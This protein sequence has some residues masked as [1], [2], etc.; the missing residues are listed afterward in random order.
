[1]ILGKILK[2][3]ETDQ[4]EILSDEQL[5]ERKIKLTK[6]LRRRNTI[7]RITL[8]FVI[9]L[10]ICGGYKSLFSPKQSNSY[11]E[12]MDQSFLNDYLDSYY[13]YPQ[14][15]QS[16]DY[17]SKF[18]LSEEFYRLEYD[19]SVE[20]AS[21]SDSIIYNVKAED[22]I[23]NIYS[24]YVQSNYSV[25]V[26]DS[27]TKTKQI[28]NK[29]TVAKSDNKYKVV[30]PVENV[31]DSVTAIQDEKVLDKY[32]Y[33]AESGSSNVSDKKKAEI[34]NTLSLFLKTYNDDIKQA[35]L[36]VSNPGKLHP[37]DG[38]TSLELSNIKKLTES[39]DKYYI[40]CNV[41][42]NYQNCLKITMSYHFE[43]DIKTNKISKMEVY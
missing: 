29:V 33:D 41:I 23:N 32:E 1:M 8:I 6:S 10:G 12:L 16:K 11:D 30:K 24:F 17:L 9:F 14:S 31:S 27:E 37:L 25:K 18:S 2:K 28:Y 35:R 39:D 5:L 7:K 43:I 19:N 22:R 13:Q 34:E 42:Q 15:K 3:E 21:S 26:K 40:E 4:E 38:D 36:L 20:T